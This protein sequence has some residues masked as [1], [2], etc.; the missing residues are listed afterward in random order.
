MILKLV[1]SQL[2]SRVRFTAVAKSGEVR[3]SDVKHEHAGVA[4]M[5]TKAVAVHS[6]RSLGQYKQTQIGL[7]QQKICKLRLLRSFIEKFAI[8]FCVGPFLCIQFFTATF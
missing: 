1:T 7:E 6:E 8:W 4:S 2:Y 3:K 5:C